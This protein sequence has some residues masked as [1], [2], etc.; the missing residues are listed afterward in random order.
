MLARASIKITMVVEND[1]HG[2][3]AASPGADRS[4]V[5]EHGLSLWIECDGLRV[6]LDTGQGP[7]IETN[8][9]AL[10]IDLEATDALVLSH[11]HYDHTGGMPY[12]LQRAKQPSVHCHPAALQERFSAAD[13]P[14]PIGMPDASQR[15]LRALPAGAVEWVLGPTML[16]DNVGVT[17]P[18]PRITEYED[19][20]GPFYLDKNDWRPDPLEDDMAL[21]VRTEEGLVVCLGCAHSGVVNTLEWIGRLEPNR[22]ILAVI[23]GMHLMNASP[24]R[25][26]ATAKVL[27]SSD[28]SLLMPCHCTGAAATAALGQHLGDRLRSGGVGLVLEF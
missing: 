1:V 16:S 18:I 13:G 20:G 10:G 21:W 6:L 27:A 9:P 7:A 8:A 4:L 5:S 24:E 2:Q 28:A 14:R 19:T 15:A 12:V 25:V 22:P 23:G 26:A 3:T 17:G 11:G